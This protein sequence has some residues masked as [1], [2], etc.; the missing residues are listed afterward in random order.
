[1]HSNVLNL[2]FDTKILQNYGM[3]SLDNPKCS[4]V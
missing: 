3:Y 1:M 2:N 4:V